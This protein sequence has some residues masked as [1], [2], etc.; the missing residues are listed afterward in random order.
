M[1][2]KLP[3]DGLRALLALQQTGNF[4]RAGEALGRS[5][6]ALSLQIRK[7]EDLT[8]EPLVDR[9]VRPV[10]LTAKGNLLAKYAQR[11]MTLEAECLAE[12]KGAHVEGKVRIGLPNDLA[13]SYLPYVL[14]NFAKANPNIALDVVSDISRALVN[15]REANRS[16]LIL[17][18]H[19]ED[20][21]L[22]PVKRWRDPVVWVGVTDVAA[23]RPLPLVLYPEGCGYRRRLLAALTGNGISARVAYSGASLSGIQAAVESGLG[24]T[25]LSH[26]TVP[27]TLTVLP[28][29]CGLPDLGSVEVALY[30]PTADPTAATRKLAAFLMQTL[31]D[32]LSV[33]D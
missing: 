32:L 21:P 18:I 4:T 11:M 29:D 1:S 26:H 8:G 15:Q 13:I 27:K 10:T 5:Q 28:R 20:S 31:D 25:A 23:R 9:T 30:M 7:L 12:I 19:E 2:D 17:A 24:V 33:A 14:G 3:M 22:R 6:A 16:D